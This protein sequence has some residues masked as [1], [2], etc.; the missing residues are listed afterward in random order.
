MYLHDGEM[1]YWQRQNVQFSI[2]S[3]HID[4]CSLLLSP[5][6]VAALESLLWQPVCVYIPDI[7]YVVQTNIS[8]TQWIRML[9]SIIRWII[10]SVITRKCLCKILF[11]TNFPWAVVVQLQ[12]W[13]VNSDEFV[14]EIYCVIYIKR[15]QFENDYL[16][17]HG[18]DNYLTL[19]LLQLLLFFFY[20]CQ[21]SPEFLII[22]TN[23]SWPP[24]YFIVWISEHALCQKKEQSHCI[25]K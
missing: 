11:T 1:S 16:N 9:F 7:D 14:N 4:S 2:L 23:I 3:Y 20:G 12:F 21:P 5:V 19:S 25:K 13:K 22:F 6:T 18:I 8:I 15:D 17:M 24:E 10:A